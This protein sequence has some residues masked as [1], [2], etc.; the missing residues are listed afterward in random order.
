M[1]KSGRYEYAL[2]VVD[3]FSGW[4]EAYAVTNMTAKTTAKK[5]LSELVC[6]F[7]VPEVIESDQGPA[8]T[9]TLTKE[10]WAALG[11]QLALHTSYHPQSSGK[12]ERMNGT[13]EDRMLKMAQETNMSWPDSL[14]IALFSVR[15]TPQGNMLCPLM[16]FFLV[17][18]PDL[19]SHSSCSYN[20]MCFAMSHVCFI[21]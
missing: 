7:G 8:F 12:V 13:L 21:N 15:H 11:V 3:M 17:Q 20:L 9:A 18:P 5:L 4:P 1:P 16:K 19:A 14:P 6:R 2:V 10:I